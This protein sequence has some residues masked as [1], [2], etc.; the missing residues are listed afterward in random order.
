MPMT[1]NNSNGSLERRM[2]R[3]LVLWTVLAWGA[4][5]LAMYSFSVSNQASNWDD[6]LQSMA[7]KL[8]E[9]Q[10]AGIEASDAPKLPTLRADVIAHNNELNFQIWDREGRLIA[11]TPGAPSAPLNAGFANGFS[12]VVVDGRDW[13]VYSVADV[14][15]RVRV[16]VGNDRDMIDAD[17]QKHSAKAVSLGALG[18]ALVGLMMWWAVHRALKPIAKMEKDTRSRSAFDLTPL[19][20]GALPAEL[21]PLVNSFNH[22]LAR[23]DQSIKAERQFIGD[24][25][26]ELRT[27]LAALQSQLEVVMRAR[28]DDERDAALRKLLLGVKRASRLSDQLLDMAQLEAGEH[29]PV[30][31][32]CDLGDIVRHVVSEFELHAERSHRHIELAVDACRMHCNVDEIGILVRNLVDNA[33]RY[34]FVGGRVR[35]RCTAHRDIDGR[36]RTVLEISDDGPGVPPAEH[37]AIFERF[38]RGSGNPGVRGAG[39]GLSLVRRIAR[40]H[41]ARIETGAGFGDPGLCV[42]LVF[43]PAEAAP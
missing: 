1:N 34:S 32:W 2:I 18:M 23:L 16:Q 17:F 22:V 36:E 38:H 20:T 35:V 42:R 19:S 5:L 31:E 13:R 41:S 25:A 24:A 12:S 33:L 8:L 28:A 10:P 6:K 29:A 26:H 27:P 7:I 39:I 21:L 4:A 40:M 9:M 30:R 11:A 37:E 3:A 15:G 14:G 43:P